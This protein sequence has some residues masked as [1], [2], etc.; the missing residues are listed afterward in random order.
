ME[1]N[2]TITRIDNHDPS[3][4]G[5]PP[6]TLKWAK[7]PARH[8]NFPL[9]RD[10]KKTPKIPERYPQNAIF[11]FLR[12]SG[13]RGVSEGVFGESHISYVGGSFWNFFRKVPAVLGVWPTSLLNPQNSLRKKWNA[14][15]LQGIPC[16][17]RKQGIKQK[18]TRERRSGYARYGQRPQRSAL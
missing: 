8:P 7:I 15:C 1:D 18:K 13:A 9:P 3:Q 14:Q 4:R 2:V 5:K 17:R 6:K 11:V 10:R 12:Y 16:K